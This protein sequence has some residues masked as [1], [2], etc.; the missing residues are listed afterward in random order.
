MKDDS[1]SFETRVVSFTLTSRVRAAD[2]VPFTPAMLRVF[3]SIVDDKLAEVTDSGFGFDVGPV[4]VTDPSAPVYKTHGGDDIRVGFV[5]WSNDLDLVRITE[6]AHDVQHDYNTGENVAW[7]SYVVLKRWNGTP[8]GG[9]GTADGWRLGF[10]H[11]S[12]G[13]V[14]YEV[15]EELGL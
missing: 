1:D 5:F 3:G 4:S 10:R 14:A 8:P 6:L 13:R 12:T 15:A 9:H 11:P 7:H 2:G